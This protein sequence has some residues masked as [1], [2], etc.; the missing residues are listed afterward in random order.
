MSD[1]DIFHDV[2]L[3]YGG[4]WDLH[5]SPM[6]DY[7]SS[8]KDAA[9]ELVDATKQFFPRMPEVYFDLVSNPGI[10]AYAFT[11]HGRYFIGVY[12]GTVF[13]LDTIFSRMMCDRRALPKVG[14]ILLERKE[15]QSLLGV[16]L[17]AQKA[18]DAG[19]YP[20]RPKCPVRQE[21][22]NLLLECAFR[23]LVVHELAHILKGH[24]DYMDKRFSVP[25]LAEMGW[26]GKSASDALTR[27][28]FEM[29]AD[30]QAAGR[31]AG[32]LKKTTDHPLSLQ[33]CA[34]GSVFAF[35]TLFHLFGDRTFTGHE[36]TQAYPPVRVRQQMCAQLWG[37]IIN[38][39][40]AD[41]R[42]T[43]LTAGNDAIAAVEFI[44]PKLTGQSAVVKGL[45]EAFG[46]VGVD[47]AKKLM[48]HFE[49]VTVPALR[50]YQYHDFDPK[51]VPG[52]GYSQHD[53]SVQSS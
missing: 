13:L 1:A 7:W 19:L 15:P 31:L 39:W 45:E 41:E 49:L 47:Y 8:F 53:L 11:S 2:M 51:P 52:H 20:L 24:V 28:S 36:S 3:P 5:N 12:S 22:H 30:S 29:D 21:Y 26:I 17:D 18:L 43:C 16:G 37:A 10:Q 40:A 44:L 42:Q 50:P 35:C 23:F 46:K 9:N 48:E 4:R 6:S 27:Q 14:N 32:G 38:D 25:F 34:F 33:E